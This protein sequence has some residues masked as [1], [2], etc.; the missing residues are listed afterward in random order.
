[1]DSARVA[2]AWAERL[3]VPAASF[4]G[5]GVLALERDDLD[6]VVGVGLGA[7][8]VVVAP[9]FLIEHLRTLDRP[10]LA[11]A[12]ALA[13]ALRRW[14]PCTPIGAADLWFTDTRPPTRE[15]DTRPATKADLAELRTSATVDEWQ[16]AGLDEMHM[17]WA[18]D[19][20]AHGEGSGC[21][22]SA[23]LAAAGYQ[24][25]GA[26]AQLGVLAAPAGRGRGFAD[27]VAGRAAR[28]AIDTG[29]IAQWRCRAGNA[30]S[31]RLAR[32]L[33][34]TRLGVQTAV[35]LGAEGG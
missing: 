35:R 5:S 11:D 4:E 24:D 27:L 28:E 30:G 2:A 33:G 19:A 31:A 1:M 18:A 8:F 16:E 25:W 7:S 29:R 12:D 15:G 34:F 21:G 23:V 26:L 3:Q 22:D 20:R 6:A 13:G 14:V 32:R 17:A 9:A 10:T